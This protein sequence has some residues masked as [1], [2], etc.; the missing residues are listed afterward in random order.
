M[1]VTK[2]RLNKIIKEEIEAVLSETTPELRKQLLG[3]L[4]PEKKPQDELQVS[5]DKIKSILVDKGGRT[6]EEA[7]KELNDQ[8][9]LA[10]EMQVSLEYA[11]KFYLGILEDLYPDHKE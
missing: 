11:V 10:D 6:E 1:K 5:L 9:E 7:E 4:F 2:E 3:D 8:L